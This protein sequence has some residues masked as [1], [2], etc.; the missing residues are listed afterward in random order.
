M[1]DGAIIANHINSGSARG[2]GSFADG[3]DNGWAEVQDVR[4]HVNTLVQT[5]QINNIIELNR[6]LK[7][8]KGTTSDPEMK[9][10]R[11]TILVWTES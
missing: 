1:N 11:L 3:T 5:K 7:Y 2:I 8:N 4:N 10:Y 6:L 9:I